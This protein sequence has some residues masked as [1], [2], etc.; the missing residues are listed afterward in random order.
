MEH[1]RRIAFTWDQTDDRFSSKRQ[2]YHDFQ[3]THI[4]PWNVIPL[5]RQTDS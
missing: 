2:L 1:E 5:D 3:E 4:R